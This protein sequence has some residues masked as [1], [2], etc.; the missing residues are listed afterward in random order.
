[1]TAIA[2]PPVLVTPSL[3][4]H[5]SDKEL[6]RLADDGVSEFIDGVAREKVMSAESN[7]TVAR[8]GGFLTIH[9]LKV[10]AGD[11]FT[12]QSF[13]CFPADSRGFRRPDLSFTAAGRVPSPGPPGPLNLVPDLAVE[14][15]SPDDEIDALEA[16]LVAY[17]S[18]GVPLIWV[19]IPSVRLVRVFPRGLSIVE[20]GVGDTLTGGA[21]L[22]GFSVSVAD[23][24]RPVVARP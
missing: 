13:R 16:K 15:T 19:V 4:R 10:P 5:Y 9:L 7:W 14:V 3:S 24:F 8:L 18:V 2:S 1:M 21:V 12:E 6:A 20:L 22:P 11:L 23:L 17:R